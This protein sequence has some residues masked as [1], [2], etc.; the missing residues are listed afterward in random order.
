MG[1]TI[2]TS[3]PWEVCEPGD[4]LDYDG[5][6]IVV[7]GEDIRIC[8]VLGTSDESKATAQL[9][10]GAPDLVTALRLVASKTVLTSGIR[11]V[12]DA[13]LSKAGCR[14]PEPIRHVRICGESL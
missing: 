13:A 7:L 2:H 8:V 3:G 4:Y 14:T 1:Q 9:I 11:A 5:N 6:C 12:V 10:A